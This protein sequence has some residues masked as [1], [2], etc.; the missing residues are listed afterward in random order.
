MVHNRNSFKVPSLFGFGMTAT[1]FWGDGSSEE[2]DNDL[3]HTYTT[4]GLYEVRVE[5]TQASSVSLPD[6]VGIKEVDLTSF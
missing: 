6:M 5:A 2:Y 4:D 3:V 1:V